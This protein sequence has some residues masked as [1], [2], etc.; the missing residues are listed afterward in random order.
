MGNGIKQFFRETVGELRK[1]SWPTRKEAL[2][3]TWIVLLVIGAMTIY[4]GVILD[5]LYTM[6]F[7]LLL[8]A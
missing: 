1:V 7:R 4:L 6:F 8:G 5:S 3:L 2:N